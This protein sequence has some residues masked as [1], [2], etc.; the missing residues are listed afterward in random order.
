MKDKIQNKKGENKNNLKKAILEAK[1][2]LF[3]DDIPVVK[4]SKQKVKKGMFDVDK[5]MAW[6]K[7]PII[8]GSSVPTNAL[9]PYST[10]DIKRSLKSK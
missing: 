4:K 8:I 10:K 1:K 3:N 2:E 6:Y 9:R 7:K 5:E